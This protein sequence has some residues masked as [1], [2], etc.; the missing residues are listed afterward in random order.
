[1]RER[2]LALLNEATPAQ[3][4]IIYVMVRALLCR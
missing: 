2:L 4:E 1:M 3:L